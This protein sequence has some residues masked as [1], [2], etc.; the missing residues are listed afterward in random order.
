MISFRSD[1]FDVL[2]IQGTLLSLLPFFYYPHFS[3]EV[4]KEVK[5]SGQISEHMSCDLELGLVPDPAFFVSMQNCL[6]NKASVE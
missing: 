1:W 6:T 3:D 2:A 4:L 5:E